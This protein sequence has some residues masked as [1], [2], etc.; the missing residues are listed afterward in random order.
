[1]TYPTISIITVVR[2]SPLALQKTLQN[3]TTIK[4]PAIELIVIDGASTDNTTDVARSFG[5]KITHLVS[6]PDSGLYD[7]MNKGIK[8]ASGDFLWFINAGDTVVIDDLKLCETFS[9]AQNL[10]IIYGQTM[11][12]DLN[13]NPIGLRAK[14]LPS[15]LTWR[16]LWVGMV[17]CHQSFIVRRSIA[18]LYNLKWRFSSD[19]DWVINCLKTSSPNRTLNLAPQILSQ[20]ELG[21]ISSNNR[22][23]SL[24]ERWHVM[25]HHYGLPITIAGH[26]V[27][28]FQALS[29]KVF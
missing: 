19:I 8:L 21:G 12:V 11:I 17:V 1:M 23:A 18:P 20:F 27:I 4:Y 25:Q 7:A 2:N 13:G 22:K 6:E 5:S 16:S 26:L 14:K 24:R 29:R 10:D 28:T 9:H 15:L 3:L